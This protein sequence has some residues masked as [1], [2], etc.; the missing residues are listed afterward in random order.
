MEAAL[1]PLGWSE[2]LNSVTADA[3]YRLCFGPRTRRARRP[4]GHPQLL[5][6]NGVASRRRVRRVVPCSAYRCATEVRPPARH[7]REPLRPIDAPDDLS[8]LEYAMAQIG[9]GII[10][11]R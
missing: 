3:L 8:F 10:L 5:E 7:S 6:R 11:P 2:R 4:L 9:E 1:V